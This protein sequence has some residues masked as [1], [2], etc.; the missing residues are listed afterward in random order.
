[1]PNLKDLKENRTRLI[2]EA[3]QMCDFDLSY[4][5]FSDKLNERENCQ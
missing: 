2:V 4:W 1:M 5:D 3:Q